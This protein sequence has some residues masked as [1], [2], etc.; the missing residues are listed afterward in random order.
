MGLGMILLY[1]WLASLILG[2]WLSPFIFISLG[3][4]GG[5]GWEFSALFLPFLIVSQYYLFYTCILDQKAFS[6]HW[7]SNLLAF[8]SWLI[9]ALFIAIVSRVN[10]MS[11][12]EQLG[13][14]SLTILFG[15]LVTF[16]LSLFYQTPLEKCL[17]SY[18]RYFVLVSLIFPVIGMIV[19]SVM[20]LL[21]ETRFI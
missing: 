17:G 16:V 3:V 19:S 7:I 12:I 1:K 2:F 14:I 13:L 6:C 21:S 18:N 15:N 10:L 9:I 11:G 5:F 20:W 4:L 8:L